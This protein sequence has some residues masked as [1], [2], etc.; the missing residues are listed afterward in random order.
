MS[1]SQSLASDMLSILDFTDI[2]LGYLDVALCLRFCS[3]VLQNW[4]FPALQQ[5]I[6]GVD[7]GMG[8]CIGPGW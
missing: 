3:L 1:G 5:F 2:P 4:L 6:D 8:L 7:I